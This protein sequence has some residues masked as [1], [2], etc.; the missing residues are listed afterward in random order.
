[1]TSRLR[2][3][4][5]VL[6]GPVL[7]ALFF[8]ATSPTQPLFYTLYS[9]VLAQA[10]FWSAAIATKSVR[11]RLRLRAFPQIVAVMGSFSLALMFLFAAPFAIVGT[12]YAWRFVARDTFGRGSGGELYSLRGYCGSSVASC[13]ARCLTCV[14]HLRHLR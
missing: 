13:L 14:G 12:N 4:T 6:V 2:L 5:G 7:L 10:L 1:M 11:R 3:L 8:V 9:Y